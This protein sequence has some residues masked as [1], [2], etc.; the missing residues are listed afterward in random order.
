M[1]AVVVGSLVMDISFRV[2]RWPSRGESMVSRC[3][4]MTPGGKGLNQAVALTR[5]GTPCALVGAVGEDEIG[6]LLMKSMESEQLSTNFMTR[7]KDHPSGI[8]VPIL[9]TDGSNAIFVDPGANYRL[10]IDDLSRS[11][12]ALQQCQVLLIQLEVPQAV[13]IEAAKMVHH[14]GGLVILDPA[15]FAPI[16]DELWQ[17][18]DIIT[19]NAHELGRILGIDPIKSLGEGLD[20]AGRLHDMYPHLNAVIATLGNLGVAVA[21]GS[22]C[23]TVTAEPIVAVDETAAGDGFNAALASRLLAGK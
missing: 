4:G 9:L 13:S 22:D 6:A 2:E 1:Q 20:A 15:P 11:R 12:T 17:W 5:L 23:F 7:V 10:T 21:N 14:N 19:P 18:V 3:G 16:S 8:A